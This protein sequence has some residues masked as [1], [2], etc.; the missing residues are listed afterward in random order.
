MVVGE[1]FHLIAESG[2]PVVNEIVLDHC[3]E[4]LGQVELHAPRPLAE[5]RRWAESL[6]DAFH[7]ALVRVA[8]RLEVLAQDAI[9]QRVVG[10]ADG[11]ADL[12]CAELAV[13]FLGDVAV[14]GDDGD[15]LGLGGAQAP[16][17]G[18]PCL[19]GPRPAIHHD[20]GGV[21]GKTL[22]DG[23]LLVA[24][25]HLHHGFISRSG[26]GDVLLLL[27]DLAGSPAGWE[28]TAPPK[29]AALRAAE[30]HRA[31]AVRAEDL[32]GRSA[33]CLDASLSSR[34]PVS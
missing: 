21:I 25:R 27:A 33:L 2:S 16:L 4:L 9:A 5:E 31:L 23:F 11:V 24:A 6:E 26:S 30:R 14:E 3:R 10:A 17:H 19:A 29:L 15:L 7:L 34:P 20:V 22:P 32:V 18:N 13:D 1:P 8:E 12:G 28:E